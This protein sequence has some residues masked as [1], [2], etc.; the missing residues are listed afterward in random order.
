MGEIKELAALIKESKSMVFFGG[1]GVSTDSG[2]PDFR[3]K[4]GSFT[5]VDTEYAPEEILSYSF[6][7]EHTKEFFEYWRKN[8]IYENAIPN[9]AHNAL[10]FLEKTGKL[11][12]I[13]TQ[14]IDGLHQRAGS[15]NVIELHGS[16]YSNY[17]VCCHKNFPLS[18]VTSTS[19]IPICHCGG[20]IR[21]DVVLYEESLDVKHLEDAQRTIEK[22]DLLLVSGTSLLV[23]PAAALIKNLKSGRLVIINLSRTIYD[24]KADLVIHERVADVLSQVITFVEET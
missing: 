2:I 7:T 4:T 11:K 18:F 15:M 3:S 20:V 6:F 24:T 17:C 1:A 22:A 10:A 16:I 8:M 5:S 14:N 19:G 13:I 12:M 23:Y 9:K 21:P